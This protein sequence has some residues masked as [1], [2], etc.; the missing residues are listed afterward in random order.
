MLHINIILLAKFSHFPEL[1][2]CR[3]ITSSIIYMF[4]QMSLTDTNK[5]C[6]Q[7]IVNTEHG[8]IWGGNEET[9]WGRRGFLV[10]MMRRGTPAKAVGPRC[11]D[12]PLSSLITRRMRT[13]SLLNPSRYKAKKIVDMWEWGSYCLALPPPAL[14]QPW[15]A[16]SLKAKVPIDTCM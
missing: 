14:N 9:D 11:I 15:P 16:H 12:R 13:G 8:W 4:D 5:M 6:G 1:F 2:I 3:L 10:P 7:M